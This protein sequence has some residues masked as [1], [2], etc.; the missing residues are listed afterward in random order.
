[1]HGAD[2]RVKPVFHAEQGLVRVV[3]RDDVGEDRDEHEEAEDDQP[4]ERRPLAEDA[5]Q[6]VAP[7]ARAGASGALG[8]EVRRLR[9]SWLDHPHRWR[10][11]GSRK[12]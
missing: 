12:P 9:S 5:P 11:R 10:I 3:G 6:R 1:M 7:E 8:E 4:D 2:R